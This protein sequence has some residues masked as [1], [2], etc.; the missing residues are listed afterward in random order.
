L[1]QN[2]RNYFNSAVAN[3]LFL[4]Y[5]EDEATPSSPAAL[6]QY[7]AEYLLHIN[8]L[9]TAHTLHPSR[10][11]LTQAGHDRAI[12]LATVSS[13]SSGNVS[14]AGAFFAIIVVVAI[15]LLIGTQSSTTRTHENAITSTS[16]CSLSPAQQIQPNT[17]AIA[18]T[19][20]DTVNIWE[21]TSKA[22]SPMYSLSRGDRVDII[23]GPICAEHYR[24]WQV[25]AV[26]GLQGWVR[27]GSD[28]KDTY[29]ICPASP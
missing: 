4:A 5:V 16:D 13:H 20:G 15:I 19:S 1:D 12:E 17:S 21:K 10:L 18:R 7:A 22:S 6:H 8:E 24:W 14:G 9:T 3:L 2:Q 25:Q 23:G 11:R 29:F 26:S 27:E 28:Q